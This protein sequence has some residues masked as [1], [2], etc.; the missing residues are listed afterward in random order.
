MNSSTKSGYNI[1]K[2][3]VLAV[4]AA[5]AYMLTFLQIPV[6]FL[7]FDT[8]DVIIAMS[9]FLFG[10]LAVIA[11]SVVVSLVEMVTISETGIFGAIMNFLSTCAFLIPASCV[12]KR[13]HSITGAIAGLA[14]GVVSTAVTM[15]LWN[16]LIVP[17]YTP[18]INREQVLGMLLPFFVPFNLIK[19]TINSAFIIMVYKPLS[20]ILRKAHML[21]PSEATAAQRKVNTVLLYA[22]SAVVIAKR[23]PAVQIT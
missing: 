5:M 12:Y 9:G 4:F 22:M 10:P 11:T 13:W 19:A 1:K 23:L 17:L 14:F 8:K 7:T 3:V 18:D 6:G 16:Y 2:L 21:P 15:S 20:D